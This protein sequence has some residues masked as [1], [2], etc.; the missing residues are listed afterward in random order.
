[1]VASKYAKDSKARSYL[2]NKI[3]KG[4]SGVWGEVPMAAHPDLKESDASLIVEYIL[5]VGKDKANPSL[6][7]TGKIVPTA[8]DAAGSKMMQISASYTDRGAPKAR[9]LTGFNTLVLMAPMLSVADSKA[10]ES[11]TIREVAK[12]KVARVDGQGGWIMFDAINLRLVKEVELTYIVP[13]KLQV[14]YV[15]EW[16]AD[17]LDGTKLGETTIGPGG[18]TGNNTVKVPLQNI[19][20]VPI[21]LYVRAR[22]VNPQETK[23]FSIQSVRFIAD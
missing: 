1:M 12:V 20:S 7:R 16:F 13:D 2:T 10:S 18:A 3:I 15:V 14:G 23:Q 4:G 8:T 6:P 9:P 19:T 17:R 5:S 21:K 11:M 22:K